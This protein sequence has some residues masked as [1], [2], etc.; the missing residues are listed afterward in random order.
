[1]NRTDLLNVLIAQTEPITAKNIQKYLHVNDRQIRQWVNE[2]RNQ[3][4]PVCS[5][6]KG[7]F[8]SYDREAIVGTIKHLNNKV[9]GLL[10]GVHTMTAMLETMND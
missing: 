4:I 8:I 6:H 2:L 9:K 3:G 10:D 7:Y 1:M 5:S